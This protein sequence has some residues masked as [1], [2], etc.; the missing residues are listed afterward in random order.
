[1]KTRF[2]ESNQG[3]GLTTGTGTGMGLGGELVGVMMLAGMVGGREAGGV[4]EVASWSLSVV[5]GWGCSVNA[6]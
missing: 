3:G 1:M 6:T 2:V 5:S 4:L